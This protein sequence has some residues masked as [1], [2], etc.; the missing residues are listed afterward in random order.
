MTNKK[1]TESSVVINGQQ[2][3]SG[4][5]MTLRVALESFALQ[6]EDGLG[7]DPAGVAMTEE[8]QERLKQIRLM[9]YK[10]VEV[11]DE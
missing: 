2:L 6:M 4:Q 11:S 3:I 5:V 7:D 10:N 9:L 1:F 8:Y